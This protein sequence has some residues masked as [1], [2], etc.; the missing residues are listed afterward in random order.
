M[1]INY[2]NIGIKLKQ[3]RKNMGLSQEELAYRCNLTREY[4]SYI[5]NGR[6]KPSLEVF[7]ILS[8]NLMI[9]VENFIAD[10][11]Q[12]NMYDL[13]LINIIKNSKD[14]EKELYLKIIHLIKRTYK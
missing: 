8:K 6:K 4:I 10:K 11:H 2:K 5:E 1:I 12:N 7:L 3:A 9:S 14:E 13:R